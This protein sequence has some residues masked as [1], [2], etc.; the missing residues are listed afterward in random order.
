MVRAI[1]I[2]ALDTRR[3]LQFR[4]F[5]DSQAAMQRLQDDRPGP[6][7]ALARRGI[8]VARQGITERG[9]DIRVEWIPGHCR[10]QGNELADGC[11]RDEATRADRVKQARE[12]RGG[13]TRQK[14][15][16]I[17]ISFVKAQVRK[18]ANKEW[19]KMV[20]SL[21]RISGHVA[22]RRPHGSI[23]KIPGEL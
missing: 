4:V 17:S 21:N 8:K 7:Q 6:G 2:C 14:Q 3:G 10:A 13:V 23:P 22:L 11:A 5:T 18:R 19:G 15:R 20:A 12:E 16:M 1:E 9:A